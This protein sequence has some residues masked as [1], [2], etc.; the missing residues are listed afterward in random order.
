MREQIQHHRPNAAPGKPRFEQ[1][2][3]VMIEG[4]GRQVVLMGDCI[5]IHHIGV[6]IDDLESGSFEMQPSD[7]KSGCPSFK[8]EMI[9]E[10][11]RQFKDVVFLPYRLQTW[12]QRKLVAAVIFEAEFPVDRHH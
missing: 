7:V 5:Q 10:V 11:N 9:G 12:G 4:L 1:P 6:Q 8:L 3:R 2:F